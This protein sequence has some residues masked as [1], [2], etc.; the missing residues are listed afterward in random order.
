MR[1]V[2]GN[3]GD[4][5]RF[6]IFNP[7]LE[8]EPL[9]SDVEQFVFAAVQAAKTRARFLGAE[10]GIEKRGGHATGLEGVDLV[11]HQRDERRDHDRQARTGERG[12]LKT[13]GFAAAGGQQ[14]EDIFT[15]EVG[16]DDFTLQRPERGVAE[17][18]LE[19]LRE[20]GH[21]VIQ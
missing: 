19:E 10:R 11:L 5:P 4:V 13:E 17:S 20:R 1:F 12:Q 9:R 3:R 7:A 16:L 8:H 15:D 21:G 18:G 6:E 14:R 2:D